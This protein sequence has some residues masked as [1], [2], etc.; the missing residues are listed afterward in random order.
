MSMFRMADEEWMDSRT[1][2]PHLNTPRYIHS[3]CGEGNT[4]YIFCG[5]DFESNRYL[6]S[7]DY[8]DM[9]GVVLGRG[10]ANWQ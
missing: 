5:H 8:L 3:S 4:V 2:L 6:S 1:T 7:I 9:S 10:D